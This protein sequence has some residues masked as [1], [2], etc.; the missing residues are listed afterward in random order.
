MLLFVSKGIIMRLNHFL[1]C[2]V[3]SI[4]LIACAQTNTVLKGQENFIGKWQAPHSKIEIGHDGNLQYKASY[5]QE[6]KTE[7]TFQ[8]SSSQSNISAPITQINAQR[9]Q[10]GTGMFSTQF[11]V[12]KAPY[13]QSGQWH[14]T[15]NNENYVKK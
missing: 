2:I 6:E 9:I 12:N 14:M 3:S 4:P 13:Q 5:Q 7:N 10:V 15:I 11:N 1:I 8:Q